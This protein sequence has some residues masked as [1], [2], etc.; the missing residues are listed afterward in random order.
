MGHKNQFPSAFNWQS[1]NPITGFIPNPNLYNGGSA[2]SGTLAGVCSGTNTIYTNIIDVSR[3][4]NIGHEVTWVG[5]MSGTFQVLV[6]NSGDN[7][8]A[9][10]FNPVL[11]QPSG[12][13]LGYAISLNQLPF[14]YF[15][16][17][18]VNSSG[19]GTLEVFNQFKDLN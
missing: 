2:P 1:T 16:L 7:F 19:S 10:T 12:S 4:D 11:T 17:Q 18:Y 9:L 13:G 6:S 8:Y 5:T 15:M 3:M 14:K